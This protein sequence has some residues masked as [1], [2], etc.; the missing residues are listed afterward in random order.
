MPGHVLHVQ[1]LFLVLHHDA[2]I[3]QTQ[4]V[5]RLQ[6][7]KLRRHLRRCVGM[8]EGNHDDVAHNFAVSLIASR[9]RS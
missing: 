6:L 9:C 1:P 5:Q 3:D 8:P 4:R 7:L 2:C